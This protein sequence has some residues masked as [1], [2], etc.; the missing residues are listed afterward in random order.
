GLV[1]DRLHPQRPHHAGELGPRRPL[2]VRLGHRR[3][4]PP[5]RGTGV[6]ASCSGGADGG[7]TA[8]ARPSTTP[9][10]TAEQQATT[11]PEPDLPEDAVWVLDAPDL[12]FVRADDRDAVG[13]GGSTAVGTVAGTELVL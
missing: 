2:D 6:A 9:V 3:T 10:T 5:A 12:T 11:R 8:D 13:L 1:L 7:P 4:V